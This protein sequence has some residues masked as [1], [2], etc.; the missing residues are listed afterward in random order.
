LCAALSAL[1]LIVAGCTNVATFDY[2]SA[3]G[4]MLNLQNTS[5]PTKTI[6]VAPFHDYRGLQEA[7]AAKFGFAVSHP[8]GDHGSFY[9]GLIPLFP[10]GYVEKEEPEKSVDFVSLG[11]FHFD[12][13]NDLAGAAE[14]SLKSS[15]LFK[16]VTRT[17]STEQSNADY[18]W[19]GRVIN[20]CYRGY[21]I[22]YGITYFLSPVLWV[23]GAPCGQSVNDLAVKFELAE[24][25]SGKVVWSYTFSG[26][27]YIT[28]WI[29]ARI[30]KDTTLYAKL[31]K[32]AM[33]AALLD[34]SQ[35]TQLLK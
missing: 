23:L 31:M 11:R 6:A 2:R 20:S 17:T 35:K 3:Y 26:S 18:I 29:Y 28:H 27:D 10:F 12:L 8:A 7:E 32:Q 14:L 21:M 5:A 16:S 25:R 24:A 30:G 33:N 4:P 9:L 19:R 1:A 15:N 13:A 34:L 22:S